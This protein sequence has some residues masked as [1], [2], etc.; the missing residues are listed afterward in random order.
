LG[1]GWLLVANRIK[2]QEVS[3]TWG[4]I[5]HGIG[6][7]TIFVSGFGLAARLGMF[8]NLAGWV[9]LK[10]TLWVLLGLSTILL[11]RLGKFWYV[12]LP[13]IL[14]MTMAAVYTAVYKPF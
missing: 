8:E 2:S 3:K 1:F 10:I 11:K 4:F 12:H 7:L 13:L 9:H 6:L 14:I 5:F